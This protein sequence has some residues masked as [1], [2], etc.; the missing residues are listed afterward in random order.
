MSAESRPFAYLRA[1][2]RDAENACRQQI[3]PVDVSPFRV[4]R[5]SRS[6]S[7][8][9]PLL[10]TDERRGPSAARPNNELYLIETTREVYVSR[11]HFEI[12]RE[13]DGFYLMDRQ[14]ALG[15]WVEGELVGG[16]RKGGRAPLNDGDVI[17]V[18]SYRSGFIFKFV[19]DDEAS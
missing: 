2:T 12:V 11:E 16:N 7:M 14:S 18:G 8:E 10:L 13:D 4:G 5:E 9:R 1:L 17:F 15:T 3:I 19:V 6:P